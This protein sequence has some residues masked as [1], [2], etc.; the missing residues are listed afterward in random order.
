[1]GAVVMAV[2]ATVM[3]AGCGS[4][5]SSGQPTPSNSQAVTTTAAAASTSAGGTNTAPEGENP[6]VEGRNPNAGGENPNS[7]GENTT[8]APAPAQQ[9]TTPAPAVLWD[10]CG[11][12]NADIAKLEYS[13][14]GKT[15]ASVSDGSGE[16]SCRWPSRTGKSEMTIVSTRQT[17]QDFMQSGRYVGFQPLSVGDRAAY[18]YRAAQDTNNIGCYIGITVPGGLVAFVTRNLQPDAGQEPCAA[19]RRIS[20]VLVEYLP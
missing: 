15:T 2:G 19:A 20:S 5:S 14:D 3:L 13:P 16:K 17:V 12:P 9:S 10:P 18:Q 11:I 4:N 1:M 8:A 6:D 7:G